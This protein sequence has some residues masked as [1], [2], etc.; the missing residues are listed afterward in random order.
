MALQDPNI[1]PSSRLD[2][3]LSLKTPNMG[4]P[5][6]NRAAEAYRRGELDTEDDRALIEQVSSRRRCRG[7]TSGYGCRA[8]ARCGGRRTRRT[9]WR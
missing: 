5:G 3:P 6:Y 9:R 8:R 1:V 7:E 4:N 2:R